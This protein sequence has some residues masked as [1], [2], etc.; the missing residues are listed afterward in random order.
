MERSRLVP[1]AQHGAS[2]RAD[3]SAKGIEQAKLYGIVERIPNDPRPFPKRLVSIA[4]R[5]LERFGAALDAWSW[6]R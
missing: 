5:A 1:L 3:L 6:K 4:G 2:L